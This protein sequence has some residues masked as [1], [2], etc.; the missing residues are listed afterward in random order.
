MLQLL[1]GVR[2]LLAALAA[3]ACGPQEWKLTDEDVDAVRGT[4]VAMMAPVKVQGSSRAAA[5]TVS[6]PVAVSV[7]CPAA[8]HVTTHGS[9]VSVCPDSGGCI[10]SSTVNIDFGNAANAWDDCE[11]TNG[12]IVHGSL[13]FTLAGTADSLAGRVE[14]VLKNHRRGPTGGLMDMEDCTVSLVALAPQGTASGTICGRA[15][16]TSW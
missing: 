8:G 2:F 4:V 3:V 15:I 11:Y 6:V 9:V 5:L 10:V 12:L 16:T 7:R 14:G 13:L 1:A